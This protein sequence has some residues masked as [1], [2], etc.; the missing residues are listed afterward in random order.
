MAAGPHCR[1][2]RCRLLT[3]TASPIAGLLRDFLVWAAPAVF[4]AIPV[5]VG[6]RV[7]LRRPSATTVTAMAM[8][9][10]ITTQKA[11]LF[12]RYSDR[13]TLTAPMRLKTMATTKTTSMASNDV[14]KGVPKNLIILRRRSQPLSSVCW[15]QIYRVYDR[16][17]SASST[18]RPNSSE[19]ALTPA[20]RLQ[21]GQKC[22]SM[23]RL[24][25]ASLANAPASPGSR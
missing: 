10:P 20:S 7:P 15:R 18:G 9:G 17:V 22:V 13:M 4:G 23:R 25:Q 21:V 6:L 8:Y 16:F 1:L 2:G 5:G 12:S 14:D 24:A 19:A 11:M 3:G